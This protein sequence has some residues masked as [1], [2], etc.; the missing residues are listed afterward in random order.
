MTMHALD[1]ILPRGSPRSKKSQAAL[2]FY[3][4]ESP[5]KMSDD[6]GIEPIQLGKR[7]LEVPNL[8]IDCTTNIEMVGAKPFQ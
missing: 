7:S 3:P 6:K 8:R 1:L 4:L 2:L 5:T